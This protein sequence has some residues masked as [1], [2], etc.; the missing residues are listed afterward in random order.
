[1]RTTLTLEDDVAALLRRI[2]ERRGVGLKEVVNQALRAGLA[3]LEAPADKPR[4]PFRTPEVKVG[5]VLVDLES[6]SGA[7]ALA[8]GEDYR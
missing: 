3:S 5:R 1:M 6:V 7:L 2:Q 4:K 8:E